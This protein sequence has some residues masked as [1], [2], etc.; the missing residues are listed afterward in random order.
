MNKDLDDSLMGKN[1][2]AVEE[3]ESVLQKK[4]TNAEVVTMDDLISGLS[5]LAVDDK[6]THAGFVDTLAKSLKAKTLTLEDSFRQIR[7]DV[8]DSLVSDL[9]TEVIL[10]LKTKMESEAVFTDF[11]RHSGVDIFPTICGKELKGE[12]L[13]AFLSEKDL[14]CIKPVPDLSDHVSKALANGESPD[15]ILKHIN[16]TVG[17]NICV[18]NLAPVVLEAALEKVLADK[19]KADTAALDPFHPLLHR[20]L[21]VP[22][23]LAMQTEC[24]FVAQVAW[25]KKGAVKKVMKELFPALH[26]K[27]I[28]SPEAFM[29]WKEDTKKE[30]KSKMKTLLAISSWLEEIKPKEEVFDDEGDEGDEEDEEYLHNPNLAF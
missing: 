8:D 13:E 19:D 21:H 9:T 23:D 5:K 3:R 1:V 27:A 10:S 4:I 26:D 14:L 18:S 25:Y 20:I 30:K 29:E 22:F 16:T 11:I 7:N 12:E 24:A 2:V 17:D 15:S 28:I 6:D